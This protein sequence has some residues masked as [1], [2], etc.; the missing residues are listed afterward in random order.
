MTVKEL[1]KHLETL[2]PDIKVVIRG[3]ENGYNDIIEI[4]PIKIKVKPD[5]KWYDGF[6][7]KS[8]DSDAINAIDLFGENK[9][10]EE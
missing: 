3:Y 9:D 5:S 4:R 1:I 6:Y 7:D 2:P 8:T 10:R